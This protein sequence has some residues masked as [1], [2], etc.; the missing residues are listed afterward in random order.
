MEIKELQNKHAGKMGFVVGAGPSLHYQNVELLKDYVTIAVNSSLPKVKFADYF[1]A[2]DIGVKNWNYYR[3]VLPKETNATALLYAEKLKQHAG[4]IKKNKVVWFNHKWWYDPKGKNYNP[5]G[6]IMTSEAEKPI[7]G[8]RTAAGSAIHFAHIMGCD[9]I[10]MLGCDCCYE[11]RKRYYWQFEGE[12]KCFRTTGERVFSS[13]NRG[14]HKGKPV[15]SHS[16]DFLEYWEA[17]ANQAT[18]QGIRVI[19]ASGGILDSF[20]RMEFEEVFEKFGDRKK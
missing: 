7:I 17:L 15:D 5:N 10:V 16:M 14:N 3:T 13:P 4:H 1:I 18:E 12:E 11:G 20:E 2:D 19:N 6:L 9:P 8:A